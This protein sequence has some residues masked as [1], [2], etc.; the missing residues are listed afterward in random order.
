VA[1]PTLHRSQI[2]P[3]CFLVQNLLWLPDPTLIRVRPVKGLNL[4]AIAVGLLWAASV[5]GPLAKAGT[6]FTEPLIKI[7]PPSLD[8]GGVPYKSSVTNTVLLENWGGGRLVGK[9][10]VP[11]PFKI[12]SGGTYRLGPSDIQ[13]VTISYTPSGA[14]IDTN[15]V[16]FTGGAGAKLPV[17]GKLVGPQPEISNGK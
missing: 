1:P 10:T 9:A 8:F 14:A 17:F 4:K 3:P 5:N 6:L 15:F 12:I 16:K 2:I 13:V 7:T 11:R